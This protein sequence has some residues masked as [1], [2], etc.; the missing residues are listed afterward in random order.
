MMWTRIAEWAWLLGTWMLHG[1]GIMTDLNW[2]AILMSHTTSY[3][4]A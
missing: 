2:E 3:M 1:D 4:T